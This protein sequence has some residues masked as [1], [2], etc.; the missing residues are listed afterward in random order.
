MRITGK[1]NAFAPRVCA[2]FKTTIRNPDAMKPAVE[3]ADF[4][5]VAH[6]FQLRLEVFKGRV[7]F[8]VER[9]IP[10]YEMRQRDSRLH[11]HIPVE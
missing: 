9:A 5:V 7:C 2:A 8:N 3:S 4:D 11:V 10:V 6:G 1:H